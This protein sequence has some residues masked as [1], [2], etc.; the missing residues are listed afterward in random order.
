MTNTATHTTATVPAYLDAN[1]NPHLDANC[2]EALAPLTDI[3][4]LNYGWPCNCCD[5]FL[6][7]LYGTGASI[8]ARAAGVSDTQRPL[9]NGNGSG[10]GPALATERQVAFYSRLVRERFVGDACDALIAAATTITAKAMSKAIDSLLQVPALPAADGTVRFTK[11][12]GDWALKGANLVPGTTVTV[13]KANG[14]TTTAVVGAII[15]DGLAKVGKAAPVQAATDLPAVPKGHYAYP[16]PGHPEDA[17]RLTFV[18][19]DVLDDGRTFVKRVIGGRPDANIA[20]N[21]VKPTLE[22]IVRFGIAEAAALYGTELGQ[23]SRCNRHLTDELSRAL[24][25]GPECRSK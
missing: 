20:R 15:S 18:R 7:S 4:G 13:T 5:D 2:A 14:D 10:N 3:T 9:G 24:G 17:P 1:G 8:R 25:I 19:V 16:L 22:A 21:L 12:N 23:C 11:V 6:R